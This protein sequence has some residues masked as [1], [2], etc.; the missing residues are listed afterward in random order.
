MANI[1][2]SVV[3][4]VD[5]R[6]LGNH[7]VDWQNSESQMCYLLAMAVLQIQHM[8]K[9][10]ATVVGYMP[11]LGCKTLLLRGLCILN[12]MENSGNY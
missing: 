10:L 2:K 9:D 8:I 7:K 11:E 12:V 3:K 6:N 5:E 4:G 1:A